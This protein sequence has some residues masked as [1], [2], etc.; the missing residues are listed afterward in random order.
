VGE[1]LGG[2]RIIRVVAFILWL[3]MGVDDDNDDV[4]RV[5]VEIVV[6]GVRGFVVAALS[7]EVMD[8]LAGTCLMLLLR[9]RFRS[10]G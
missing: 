5:A 8:D 7:V 2:D 10:D 9:N 6:A 1:S 3:I 4:G